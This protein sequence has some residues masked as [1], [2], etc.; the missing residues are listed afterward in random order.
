MDDLGPIEALSAF[1]F[2]RSGGWFVVF[3]VVADGLGDGLADGF[4]GGVS[5]LGVKKPGGD[6]RIID[7]FDFEKHDDSF[8]EVWVLAGVAEEA[9]AVFEIATIVLGVSD[10]F[11]FLRVSAEGLERSGDFFSHE[12]REG[13][14]SVS[15]GIYEVKVFPSGVLF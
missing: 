6:F 2:T 11:S 14:I 7:E 10:D 12:V 15:V 3:D 5:G 9:D 8:E 4:A 13:V 1:G